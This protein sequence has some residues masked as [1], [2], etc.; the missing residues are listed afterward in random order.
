MTEAIHILIFIDW[1]SPGYKAGGP[2]RSIVHL[3]EQLPY[4]FSVVTSC[5]DHQS[6]QAYEGIQQGAWLQR[7]E[8]LEVMYLNPKG[9]TNA[10]LKQVIKERN[11]DKIYLN[12]MFSM[13]FSVNPMK[14]AKKL[15]LSHQIILAPRGMLK[16][17]ALSIKSKKKKTFLF[18]SKILGWH[19]GISWHATNEKEAEEIRKVFGKDCKILI[20]PNLP[21]SPKAKLA[22]ATKKEGE[23]N[24]VS[25]ARVSREKNLLGGLKYLTLLKQEVNWWIYGVKQDQAYLEE[26][27]NLAKDFPKV[28][29]HFE[30]DIA[31]VKMPQALKKG[32]FFYSPTLGENY[33]HAIVEALV[34]GLPVIISDKTP[35]RNLEES[36]A[37]WDLN[38]NKLYF[39]PVLQFCS[40]LDEMSYQE[41]RNGAHLLGCTIASDEAAI[42][43]NKVLFSS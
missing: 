25:I 30:G 10:F 4:R 9:V 15:G 39:V 26:M 43:A 35:W 22:L 28:K 32:H 12:S 8:N 41:W 38:L 31:P 11:A 1:F 3:C 17:G 16:A 33:G 14:V 2:I 5:F 36:K 6:D 19:K 42:N 34:Y 27:K 40:S 7:G 13:P 24:L 23:L 20:A 18:T 21:S 37:G 29:L